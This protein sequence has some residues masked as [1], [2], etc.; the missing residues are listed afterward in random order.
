MFTDN[1]KYLAVVEGEAEALLVR[2]SSPSKLEFDKLETLYVVGNFTYLGAS[3]T[4]YLTFTEI[5]E[6]SRE[7]GFTRFQLGVQSLVRKLAH[8]KL[9]CPPSIK[10]VEAVRDNHRYVIPSLFS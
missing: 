10:G 4:G 8:V 3:K 7:L 1:V 9:Q 5:P 2:L 6:G